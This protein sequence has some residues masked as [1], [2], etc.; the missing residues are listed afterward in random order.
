MVDG[1]CYIAGRRWPELDPRGR[2]E[3]ETEARPDRVPAPG[4]G[5]AGRIEQERE[6][7]FGEGERGRPM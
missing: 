4:G 6:A 5:A 7:L 2:P 1:G 3:W